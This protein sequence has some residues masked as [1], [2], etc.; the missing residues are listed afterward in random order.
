MEVLD[1][2]GQRALDPTRKTG[3]TG[4]SGCIEVSGRVQDGKGVLKKTDGVE[5]VSCRVRLTHN[6]D[7]VRTRR[8]A[9]PTLHLS[10][11]R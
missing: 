4:G 1:E 3:E 5:Q 2:I 9:E 10:C 6:R 11:M 8:D 7:P